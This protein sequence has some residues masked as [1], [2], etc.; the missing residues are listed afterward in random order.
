MSHQ[1]ATLFSRNRECIAFS[2]NQLFHLFKHFRFRALLGN[3]GGCREFGHVQSFTLSS[4][5]PAP[6]AYFLLEDLVSPLPLSLFPPKFFPG[7][8]LAL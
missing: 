3:E 8:D 5:V 4:R 1:L 6:A 2:P 7:C